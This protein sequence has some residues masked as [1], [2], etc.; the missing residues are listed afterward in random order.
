MDDYFL[1][2]VREYNCIVEEACNLLIDYIESTEQIAILSKYH[3][4]KYFR[5]SGKYE[6]HIGDSIYYRHGNGMMVV[7]NDTVVIDWDFGYRSWWCGIDPFFMAETLKHAL[8][9]ATAYYDGNYIKDKCRYYM[10]KNLLYFYNG[11][12]YIDLVKCSSMKI[13]FPEEY[14]TLVVEYKGAVRSFSRCKIIDRFIRKSRMIYAGIAE[15]KNNCTLIFFNN[16]V[17]EARILYN[18]IAYPKSA[19]KIMNEQILAG[20]I[21]DILYS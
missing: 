16:N 3:L 14:D 15:L 9:E 10:S 5:N 21:K 4:F 18:D 1:K 2:A 17:E 13:T 8:F 19:V 11:Q 12:Y 7:R 20:W 6:F